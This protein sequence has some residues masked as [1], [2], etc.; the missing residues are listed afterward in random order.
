MN[1]LQSA[2]LGEDTRFSKAE[3]S[4]QNDLEKAGGKDFSSKPER[5]RRFLFRYSLL[6]DL[7]KVVSFFSQK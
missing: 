7:E 6:L 3:F 4:V 5:I 2:S 1:E